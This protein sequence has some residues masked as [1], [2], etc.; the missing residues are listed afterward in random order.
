MK[1]KKQPVSGTYEWA[2]RSLNIDL[3]C[4]NGCLYCYARA[5]GVRHGRGTDREAWRRPVPRHDTTPRF[6]RRRGV[7][8]YPTQ[9][10]ICPSNL[11]RSQAALESLLAPG[12]RVLIVSK[13]RL[14]CIQPM[15]I[16]L[17]PHQDRV[18][19]RFTIGSVSDPVL[20]LWEPFAPS[21]GERLTCLRLAF[22]HGYATSVSME[23]MLDT[24]EERIAATVRSVRPYVTDSIWLGKAN[25]LIRRLKAN[26]EWQGRIPEAAH[27]L[28]D[29]Q[30]D[31]RIHALYERFEGDPL[32]RW[33]DSIKQVVGLDRPTEP[34]LDR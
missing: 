13:P 15:L 30:R 17:R 18:L 24:H 21:S 4:E 16:A 32:I 14:A 10:D 33:K 20:G 26:G 3:G 8:M 5:S 7:T 34:G 29:S 19:F 23:P 12:N 6:G 9:H 27:A 28:L 1:P 2:D 22:G 11:E 25:H 31:E